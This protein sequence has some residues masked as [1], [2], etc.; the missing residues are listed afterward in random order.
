MLAKVNSCAVVGLDGV[1]IEVEVYVGAGVPGIIIVGLPDAAVQESRERVRAAIRNSGGRVPGGHVTVNL[2]PAD[3][4][5]AGPT[6]DLPIAVGI[7]IASRQIHAEVTD[8]LIVGELSL[9]GIVRH[10]PGIISMVSLASQCGLRRAVV[11]ANDA[12]EAALIEGIDIIGVRTLADVV[13]YLNGDLPIAPYRPGEAPSESPGTLSADFSEIRGQ[14]HV[15]RALEIAAAGAHNVLMSGPPGSGKT[16]LARAM[17]G[18]LPPMS[19]AESLEV[20]KIYSVRGLLPPE[21][22]LVRDRPFRSPHH[23]TSN[24]GLI[25]GGSWPRPG[26]VSLAHRGVLFLDEMPEFMNATLEMLRQPLEDRRVSVARASGTVTFPANF[27]LIGAMNPCPC[28]YFGDPVRE[29]RCGSAQ[30]QRYQKKISGPLLDRI[31]IH[32]EVPRV[33]YDKLAAK[34]S[35]ESSRAIQQRVTEARRRQSA[36]LSDTDALTNADMGAR[37]LES[38]VELDA[39][40]EAMMRNAVTQLSLSPRSYHRVLKL[41][42]TI[43]DLEG[44]DPVAAQHLAEALQ[45]RPRQ[46][47]T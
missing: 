4:K 36:R 33:E 15:K 38:F 39:V 35:G 7:L 25:G 30:I 26:E 34:R 43:A 1:L 40:G 5:K 45:Y 21:T 8:T 20:T 32:V 23:G 12:P 29:C 3:L 11:P 47:V 13:N 44:S 10:T 46:L 42:R 27:M 19:I 16:M 28:G 24:A 31:D 9:D 37:E 14:E 17:P 6:Y 2:A 22:P 18:I 41:A